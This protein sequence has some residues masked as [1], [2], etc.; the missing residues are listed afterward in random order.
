MK[1]ILTY[2]MML[3]CGA[4]L[5]MACES[6]RDSNP[7]LQ[8][9]TTFRLNTPTFSSSTIVLTES[10]DL[11]FQWSQPDYGIPVACEYTLQFSTNGT[12]ANTV[13]DA[14]ADATG[15]TVADLFTIGSVQTTPETTVAASAINTML[16][17]MGGWTSEDDVPEVM[18][19]SA[20]VLAHVLGSSALSTSEEIASNVITFNVAPSY[21]N[22]KIAEPEM[23]YLVGDFATADGNWKNDADLIGVGLQPMYAASENDY[24]KITGQGIITY[25]GYFVASRGFKLVK[26]PGGW[27]DQWGSADGATTGTKNDGGS[28]NFFVPSDGY[29][30]ITLNTATDEISIVASDATPTQWT[31]MC[32]SG[33]FNGWSTDVEMTPVYTFDTTVCHDWYFDLDAS[34]GATTAKFLSNHAWDANW[35]DTAFPYGAGS[36][37]GPNI[38]VSEGTY[39]VFFNDITGQY[40]F[41]AK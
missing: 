34:S 36:T 10:G 11:E 38:P 13:A 19:I 41:F 31:S 35:G 15:Q 8:Q 29:Y 12:F 23:W 17:V 18:T 3:C 25:T 2:A 6:D 30:T 27:N 26:V 9:P 32:I 7:T 22:S 37:N 24:D 4:C 16:Q 33:D 1:K 28:Q 39:R 20:R 40:Y 5:F 21:V 14:T